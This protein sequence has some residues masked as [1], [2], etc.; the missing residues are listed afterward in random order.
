MT[1]AV[2]FNSNPFIRIQRQRFEVLGSSLPISMRTASTKSLLVMTSRRTNSGHS[3]LNHR[4]GSTQ[5][6]LEAPHSLSMGGEQQVWEL[7]LATSIY[8]GHS[9]YTSPI[10][11]M[12]MRAS[13]SQ[14]N[15]FSKIEQLNS[16][17]AFRVMKFSDLA[18]KRLTSITMDSWTS[19][20]PTVTLINM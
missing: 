8:Q 5:R 12:R 13:I 7:L 20:S 1:E 18:L 14:R 6:C 17:L 15:L 16:D 10:S 2:T 3:T 4:T 11:R 9:I 19:L